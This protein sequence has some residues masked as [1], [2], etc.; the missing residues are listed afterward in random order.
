MLP[1]DKHTSWVKSPWYYVN[2]LLEFPLKSLNLDLGKM[3]Q[4]C[5]SFL[6]KVRENQGTWVLKSQGKSRN[7]SKKLGLKP[8][9]GKIYFEKE[10][11]G[12]IH[13]GSVDFYVHT[14]VWIKNGIAQYKDTFWAW[15]NKKLSAKV[16]IDI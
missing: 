7:F 4:P 11:P 12:K 10:T 8:C 16:K 6:T 14:P 2:F 15:W 3:C 13:K 1:Y 5:N 9:R